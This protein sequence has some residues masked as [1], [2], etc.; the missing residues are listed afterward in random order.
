[1][2]TVCQKSN[3]MS[4]TMQILCPPLQSGCAVPKWL[5]V[6]ALCLLGLLSGAR[7]Q[8]A[9]PPAP[10]MATPSPAAQSAAVPAD[11]PVPEPRQVLMTQAQKWLAQSEGKPVEQIQLLPL[12]ERTVVKA[13]ATP[14]QFDLPFAGRETLRVRC[15]TPA[16]KAPV[17][18]NGIANATWQLYLRQAK[19]PAAMAEAPLRAEPAAPALRK[20]VVAKQQI[21]RGTRLSADM[22]ELV[23][24]AVPQW[25]PTMLD[26]LK[27]LA[28][29]EM[30]RDLPAGSILQGHDAKKAVLV[31]QGQTALL[32]LGEDRGFRISVKVEALQDGRMGEQIRLKNAESGK[33][34]SGVVSGTSAVRGI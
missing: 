21:Q 8:T 11:R 29:M 30:V 18:A 4:T 25:S 13:C 10:S 14:L 20:V 31:K 24:R 32:T 22:F 34:L 16:G 12:D 5:C 17:A 27:E 6:G 1:M 28:Q 7:A 3:T 19:A 2:S 23:E 15:L 26:S 33:I 9:K